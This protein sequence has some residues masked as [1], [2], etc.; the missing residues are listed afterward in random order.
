[1]MQ[2]LSFMGGL[3][4]GLASMPH[5]A[6]MCGPIASSYLFYAA[7]NTSTKSRAQ[8]LLLAQLGKTIS[9]IAAGVLVGGLGSQ[10]YDVLDR[11][12][13]FRV[14]QYLSAMTLIAIGFSLAGVIPFLAAFN[15]LAAPF[16][17]Q[18]HKLASSGAQSVG[19]GVS[20]G[21]FGSTLTPIA[22]G[23]IWGLVPCGMVYA[24]LFSA[25]LSGSSG[26]AAVIMSG[27]AIGVIPGVTATAL[28]I[29][30]LPRFIRSD[31]TRIIVGLMIVLLGFLTIWSTSPD[32]PLYCAPPV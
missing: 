1:M 22:S 5:C 14:L 19:A 16:T 17:L 3:L 20:T 21:G 7:P 26:N 32:S 25:M 30:T 9:Y 18:M 8:I 23:M 11:D 4:L 27:F 24:A 29:S 12:L 28:G 15:R 13:A 10:A 6:A 31:L 2:E